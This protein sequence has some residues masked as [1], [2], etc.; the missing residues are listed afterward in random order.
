MPAIGPAIEAVFTTYYLPYQP[1][2]PCQN[3]NVRIVFSD[4]DLKKGVWA[5][6]RGKPAAGTQ[7]EHGG[8]IGDLQLHLH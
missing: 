6:E 1:P 3:T 7:C 2:E 8:A 5:V 4:E